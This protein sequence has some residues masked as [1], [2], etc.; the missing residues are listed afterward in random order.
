MAAAGAAVELFSY[1]AAAHFF[2]DPGVA[3]YDEPA[4]A[5]AW[6]RGLRVLDAL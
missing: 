3:D 1:P 4:A 6:D 2:S 5:L